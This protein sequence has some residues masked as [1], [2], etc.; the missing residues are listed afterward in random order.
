MERVV[1]FGE[2][3]REMPNTM[4]LNSAVITRKENEKGQSEGERNRVS[5]C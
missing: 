4:I 5:V 1:R 3:E 2:R